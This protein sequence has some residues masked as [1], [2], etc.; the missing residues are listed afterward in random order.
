MR[1][2][3]R[4]R[5]AEPQ[6]LLAEDGP[7]ARV[8]R[9]ALPGYQRGL[10]ERHAW[11]RFEQR[12]RWYGVALG[13]RTAAWTAAAAILTYVG[14]RTFSGVTA[15]D[16]SRIAPVVAERDVLSSPNPAPPPATAVETPPAPLARPLD[17][18]RTVLPDG[19]VAQLSPGSSASLRLA[20][21]R[22]SRIELSH[23]E[24]RLE[25]KPQPASRRL[26][27]QAGAYRFEVIGTKF[28]VVH[29][30]NRVELAVD[31]GTVA[32]WSGSEL[33]ERVEAG[34]RWRPEVPRPTPKLPDG[35]GSARSPAAVPADPVETPRPAEAVD[36]LKYAR[37]G[38][39]TGAESCFEDRSKGS[40]LGAEMALY[41][42][43]RLRKDVLGNPAGAHDAL[44]EYRQRFPNGS[45]LGEVDFSMV[46]VLVRLERHEEALRESE[47]LLQSPFG[48]ERQ[49]QLRFLRGN[50]YK[51]HLNDCARAEAEYAGAVSEPG[52]RG[53]TAEYNRALCLEEL[54]RTQEA[55]DSYRSYL[56]RPRPTR[57]E[58]AAARLKALAP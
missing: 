41:E 2:A 52:A 47:R 37:Q 44:R 20:D 13:G 32:V 42:L 45:L 56:R 55:V 49:G 40:G 43:A 4:A 53:D 1:D 23:G 36:C 34:G 5:E 26:E 12:R 14:L 9:D 22:P 35:I 15:D 8:L 18:G 38:E 19:S 51:V 48:R 3:K 29:D 25:V 24:V 16:S 46:E 50:I 11:G 31:E 10:D 57:G 30:Q 54:G 27:V 21:E 6:R 28:R 39:H 58:Q 7:E 17:V 33:L